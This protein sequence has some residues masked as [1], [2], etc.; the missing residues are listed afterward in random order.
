MKN[1]KRWP[2]SYARTR[3]RRSSASGAPAVSAPPPASSPSPSRACSALRANWSGFCASTSTAAPRSDGGQSDRSGTGAPPLGCAGRDPLRDRRDQRRAPIV[4][5]QRSCRRACA[6]AAHDRRRGCASSS[7]RAGR[8]KRS[9]SSKR[10]IRSTLRRSAPAASTHLRGAANATPYD[11]VIEERSL[12]G[13]VSGG[14]RS[15]PSTCPCR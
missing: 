14:V 1:L 12:R 3:S 5:G 6:R 9:I 10:P 7:W 11:D 8:S 4:I 15:F 2:G 13:S